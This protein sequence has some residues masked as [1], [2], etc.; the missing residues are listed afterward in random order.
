MCVKDHFSRPDIIIFY[1]LHKQN[2]SITPVAK[3]S[4]PSKKCR[5]NRISVLLKLVSH[6]FK[7]VISSSQSPPG[8]PSRLPQGSLLYLKPRR[9][10][11]SN[12]QSSEV[13]ALIV[14][15]SQRSH[16]PFWQTR[17]KNGL[18]LNFWVSGTRGIMLN[19]YSLNIFPKQL[20]L[21][22]NC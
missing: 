11:F 5:I 6:T 14:R 18:V 13:A 2:G 17:L 4:L 22:I 3:W 19:A 1:L 20:T 8:P 16:F 15:P 12:G 7:D 21:E 10:G 9:G